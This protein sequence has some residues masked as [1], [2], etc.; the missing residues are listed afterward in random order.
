MRKKIKNIQ[1]Q[2]EKEKKNRNCWLLNGRSVCLLVFPFVPFWYEN[3]IL[4]TKIQYLSSKGD[5][6]LAAVN[7]KNV[8]QTKTHSES[9]SQIYTKQRRRLKGWS[10]LKFFF[11]SE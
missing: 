3:S 5:A 9:E 7:F 11:V 10:F 8:K 2:N 1:K 6:T 4:S